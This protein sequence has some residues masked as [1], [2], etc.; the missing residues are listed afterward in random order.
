MTFK[1]I[2]FDFDGV[3]LESEYAGNLQIANY[4]SDIGHPTT[5]AESMANFMGLSGG[6]FIGALE[7]WIGRTL[8]DDF[9]VVRRKTV[10]PIDP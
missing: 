6:D 5:P 7:R 8:P 4:L 1:G 10:K 3:L 2:I 9:H